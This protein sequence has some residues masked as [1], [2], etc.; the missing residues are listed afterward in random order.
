MKPG[1]VF[2][3]I[4]ISGLYQK[5]QAEPSLASLGFSFRPSKDETEAAVDLSLDFYKVSDKSSV[6]IK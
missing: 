6:T 1:D 2:D 3:G 5:L 4:A